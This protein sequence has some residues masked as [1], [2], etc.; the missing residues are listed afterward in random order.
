MQEAL[1][2][3]LQDLPP[4][5]DAFWKHSKKRIVKTEK[6]VCDHSFVGSGGSN[7]ECKNCGVGFVLSLGFSLKEGKLVFNNK[8]VI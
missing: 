2:G 7:V 5:E 3:N 1:E 8:V 4:S 6:K